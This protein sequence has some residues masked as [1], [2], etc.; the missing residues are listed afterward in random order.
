MTVLEHIAATP[1]AAANPI[2]KG[3]LDAECVI[4]AGTNI[5]VLTVC[6]CIAICPRRYAVPHNFIVIKEIPTGFS[7][8]IVSRQC[9]G[10]HSGF[11]VTG[12]GCGGEGRSRSGTIWR[13]NR[14]APRE[15]FE[16]PRQE[17]IRT[18]GVTTMNVEHVNGSLGLDQAIPVVDVTT[19]LAL[20][21]FCSDRQNGADLVRSAFRVVAPNKALR[22]GNGF[23]GVGKEEF[24]GVGEE[25]DGT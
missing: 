2:T 4:L 16:V 6:L 24:C 10:Q 25:E 22:E 3:V 13:K 23:C 9:E 7:P 14:L 21:V 8:I 1:I 5:K 12:C 17:R 15:E 19:V 20:H 11:N 18:T